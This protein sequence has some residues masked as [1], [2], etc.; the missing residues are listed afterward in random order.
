MLL[1]KYSV[2]FEGMLEF[3]LSKEAEPIELQ[4]DER[5]FE[6]FYAAMVL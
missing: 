3:G 1:A 5:D 4:D 6:A 2:V